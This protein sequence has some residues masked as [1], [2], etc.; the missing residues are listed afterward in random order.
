MKSKASIKSHPIHP[1]LVGFPIALFV[2]TFVF[3]LLHY[4]NHDE[5]Y[6]A[7]ARVLSPI[8]IGTALLAAVPGVIDF[9][10]TVPP[11][12]SGKTRA[13]KHGLLN[14]TVVILFTIACF[15]REETGTTGVLILESVGL[16]LMCVA[17]WLGGTLVYRNQIG[18]DP[19]YANAGKWN[20]EYFEDRPEIRAASSDELKVNQ[21]KLIHVGK[22]R[23]VIGRTEEGFKAFDDRCPHRGASLAGGAMICGTVQ[24]PWHGSQFNVTNGKVTAGPAT[25]QIHT[26]EVTLRNGSIFVKTR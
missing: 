18:V 26:Y 3:D 4:M 9:I 19:R 21:M 14:V 7:I 23:I 22:R 5:F 10:Y 2:I 13:A 12:S 6:F 16:I 11:Q 25:Q 17:G 1:I 8:G 15:I 20:E 24:C